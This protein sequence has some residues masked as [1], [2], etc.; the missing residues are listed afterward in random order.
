[1]KNFFH[2][3]VSK[4]SQ[5]N[6]IRLIYICVGI[7]LS[8]LFI[9]VIYSHAINTFFEEDLLWLLPTV[10][11]EAKN[12]SVFQ[13]I[14]FFF[15]QLPIEQASASLKIYSFI[16]MS[17]F[18]PLARYFIFVSVLFHFACSILLFFVC[19]KL[20]LN[21]KISFF[22]AL[23][24]LTLFAHFHAYMWPMAFQ[25]LIVVF[26]ILFVLNFYLR[27][28]EL[29]SSNKKYRSYYILTLIFNLVASFS[30]ASIFI[31]PAMIMTHILFCSKNHDER[32]R[33]YDIWLPLF[34]TYLIY[35][36]VTFAFGETRLFMFFHNVNIPI[37]TKY[38][39]M[40]FSGAFCLFTLRVILRLPQFNHFIK[41]L[42][43]LSIIALFVLA[44]LL[45]AMGGAK[46]L[47]IPYNFLVPF[48]GILASFIHPLT[49][50]FL[51][52]SVRTYHFIP[53]QLDSYSLILGILIIIIFIKKFV[54]ENKS[55]ITLGVWYLFALGYLYLRNPIPS[56]YFIFL[57]PIFCIAFCSVLFY[58]IMH[59]LDSTRLKIMTKETILVFLLVLL[60]LPNL[61]AIKLALFRGKLVNSFMTYD[62]IRAANVIRS[63]LED[64]YGLDKLG[65]ED[66]YVNK[67]KPVEFAHYK[68]FSATDKYNDNARYVFAQVFDKVPVR[69]KFNQ[70]PNVNEVSLNYSLEGYRI[71]NSE[72]K[73]SSPFS[74]LFNSGIEQLKLKRYRQANN[75]FRQAVEKR[76][77]LFNYL[78]SD[79][80]IEDL[81]WITMGD[82]HSWVN[83]V[84]SFY[85]LQYSKPEYGLIH[86][87]TVLERVSYIWQILDEEIDEYI[88]CLFFLS[89]LEY[90]SKDFQ[91]SRYWFSKI[92]FL[93]QDYD[94][95]VC[96]LS[97]VNLIKTDK[98]MRSFL[99]Q[100]N[101]LSLSSRID[102]YA[103]RF[104]FRKFL[105]NLVFNKI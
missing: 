97:K 76:P 65:V 57:S 31:L 94:S 4:L 24:Y 101:S 44:L 64:T 11:Q 102:D 30:R 9:K 87:K 95:L 23:V 39:I 93:E 14:R 34:A 90:E 54:L 5:I 48:L 67:I 28:D 41:K 29:I 10:A 19:K 37:F 50:V 2:N 51:I 15:S 49:N 73:N 56:R 80:K 42:K 63:N 62:F 98:N 74:Q 3:R 38:L 53:F 36:L 91:A 46:R 52:D 6:T 60:C 88:Q 33:K 103:N 84:T 32:I 61:M 27:T 35:P 55:L 89:Y 12:L 99:S 104:R 81:R 71:N 59:L 72:G 17:L 26:F 86:E 13:L 21:S 79:L 16:I 82:M 43:W 100:R 85:K 40:F 78:L 105:F 22:S 58:F 7:F 75:L 96:R 47:L 1:M 25:H 68:G 83:K 69:I 8:A 20:G 18:G 45:I 66:I 92:R 77:F 70:V